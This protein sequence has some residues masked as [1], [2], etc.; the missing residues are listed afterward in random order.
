MSGSHGDDPVEIIGLSTIIPEDR[1]HKRPGLWIPERM[2]GVKEVALTFRYRGDEYYS[3][4]AG[5]QE[6]AEKLGWRSAGTEWHGWAV[7]VTS[8]QGPR[9]GRQF[10]GPLP[11]LEAAVLGALSAV[12]VLD[13]QRQ[14]R[15]R[16]IAEQEEAADGES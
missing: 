9:T 13:H 3:Y 7:T 6:E 1:H 12:Y 15:E 16:R 2:H 14:E 8:T 10:I 5:T 4:L 11:T